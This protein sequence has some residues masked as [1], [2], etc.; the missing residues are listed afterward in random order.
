MRPVLLSAVLL[1]IAAG[2]AF[3]Q[4]S[5]PPR[6]LG[7]VPTVVGQATT[8]PPA[9]MPLAADTAP[10]ARP[11]NVIGTG[12]SLPMSDKAGNIGPTDTH[13]PYAARLP[14]P[15]VGE[16]TDP[17]AFLTA[18]RQALAANRTGEA[19]E[20]LERAESRL[21]V[22]SVPP[23]RA[24]TPSGQTVI[25]QIAAARQALGMGDRA[26]AL[27]KIDEALQNP[28]LAEPVK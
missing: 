23:S 1:A 13:T 18:A 2:P 21:L 27:A 24:N 20:A 6:N 4:M 25:Q 3:A 22:R 11:G 26:G 19:Q 14:D 28:E 17:H 12:Q 9:A 7:T 16:N 8:T 15:G 5:P 10:I